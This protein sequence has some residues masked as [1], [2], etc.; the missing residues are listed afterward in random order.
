[1][2]YQTIDLPIGEL[3]NRV[4]RFRFEMYGFFSKKRG[5]N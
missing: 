5:G 1:M 3:K 4:P 2:L